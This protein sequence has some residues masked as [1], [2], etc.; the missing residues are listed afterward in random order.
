MS[1]RNKVRSVMCSKVAVPLRE[2]SPCSICN[3]RQFLTFFEKRS[4]NSAICAEAM[5]SSRVARCSSAD[6]IGRT[7]SLA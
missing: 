2:I 7:I 1:R 5:L 4:D 6:R 3:S